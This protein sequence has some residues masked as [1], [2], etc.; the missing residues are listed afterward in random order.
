[1]RTVLVGTIY[2]DMKL[3]PNILKKYSG[4]EQSVPDVT[5]DGAPPPFLLS[6]LSLPSPL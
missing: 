4:E 5:A 3:K 1:V 2:K 6:L